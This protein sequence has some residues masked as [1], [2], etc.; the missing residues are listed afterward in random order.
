MVPQYKLT[1][2]N[3]KGLGEPLR[4]LLKYGN[5]DFEDIRYELKDW[6]QIKDKQPFGQLPTLEHNGKVAVQSIAIAR[7]LAKQVKLTGAND[8]EDLEIDSVI[9]TITDLRAKIISNHENEEA[10]K[11]VRKESIPFYLNRLETIAKNNKGHLAVGKL[12]WA[13]VYFAG[14]LDF[15]NARA[16]VNII[17][18]YPNLQKV[19]DT[20]LTIPQIKKWVATRP[21]TDL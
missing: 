8:W 10:M 7:Y 13:D 15:I 9:D 5:L 21:K 2:F 18:K 17:E 4:F 11:Q 6:P 12:T 3:L 14:A 19:V 16:G 1:Y 20:V